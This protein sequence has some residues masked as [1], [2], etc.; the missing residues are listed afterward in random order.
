MK[1][2]FW[3]SLIF[4]AYTYAGY[5]L[6]LYLASRFFPRRVR[7]GPLEPEPLVSVVIAARD[8]EAFIGPKIES[9]LAQDYP[10]EKL[11]IIVVSDGSTDGT[12]GV[13]ER[14]M[15]TNT[16][17]VYSGDGAAPRLRLIVLPT[18]EGKPCALNAGVAAARGEFI[19]FA[20]ARQQF[21]QSAVRALMSNFADPEVGSVSGQLVFREDSRTD[22]KAEM[23]LYWNMEKWIRRTE[24]EIHSGAGAT[25][26]IYAIRRSLFESIP[27]D[28]ILDDVFVPMKIVCKG[29]RNVFEA[30]AV[31]YDRISK[32]LAAEQR[33]KVRT[34]L[35]N[36]QLLRI[37]PEL[38]SPVGN[39]I[40][41]QFLSHKILRLFVPFFFLALMLSSAL[42]S[43]LFYK[44]VFVG[45]IALLLLHLLN[46]QISGVP[47]LG[48]A[49]ALARTFV[50]LN[51]FAF[52]AFFHAFRSGKADV[53][54]KSETEQAVSGKGPGGPASE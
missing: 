2:L 35:G 43:G 32:D 52:L 39:P 4:I 36:Y 49:S 51:S 26:A 13:V 18:N 19:V 15:A 12:A 50:S 8:E 3:L 20:D 45:T 54:K 40:F 46:R 25:G 31:A 47:V 37:S 5:P 16:Q 29:R 38:A 53:W 23:G 21:E 7:K 10:P 41:L 34:L 44:V 42:V 17:M 48:R 27:R 1:L 30:G 11:E 6:L 33:R 22:I 24:G 28:T 14:L 9:I